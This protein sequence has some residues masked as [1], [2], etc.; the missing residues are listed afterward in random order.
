ILSGYPTLGEIEAVEDFV[1]G[2]LPPS[3]EDLRAR[4]GNAPLAIVVFASEYRPSVDT[5]HR[6]HADHCFAR[7][8]ISRIGAHDARYD[9]AARGFNPVVAADGSAIAVQ[10]CRYAAYIAV[11]KSGERRT[12]G[13]QQFIDDRPK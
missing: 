5:V 1:Y 8:G 2:V 4:A 7:T 11:L 10:P 3:I 6:K 12:H 13:P 9:P